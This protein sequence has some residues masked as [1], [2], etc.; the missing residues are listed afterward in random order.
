VPAEER[1]GLPNAISANCILLFPARISEAVKPVYQKVVEQM[2]KVF[3]DHLNQPQARQGALAL[4]ALCVGDMVLARR[5]S[6]GSS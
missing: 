4:V 5:G 6:A 2:V 1:R 3:E